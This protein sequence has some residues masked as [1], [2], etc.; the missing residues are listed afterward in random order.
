MTIV[1]TILIAVT[2]ALLSFE[3]LFA[4]DVN[5][6]AHLSELKKSVVNNKKC[7]RRLSRK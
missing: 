7:R 6:R 3:L 1:R 4:A 2:A 5:W